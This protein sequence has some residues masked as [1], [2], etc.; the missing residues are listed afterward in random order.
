M[1]LLV[2]CLV[3]PLAYGPHG[4]EVGCVVSCPPPAPKHSTA[5]ASQDGHTNAKE[6]GVSGCAGSTAGCRRGQ[7]QLRELQGLG[8]GRFQ[9][10]PV[11]VY[12]RGVEPGLGTGLW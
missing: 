2:A 8:Q 10:R 9:G 4:A 1:P 6:E 3:F 7:S 5:R 12:L 11:I